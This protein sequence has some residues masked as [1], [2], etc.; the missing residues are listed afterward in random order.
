MIKDS[1]HQDAT[2]LKM[3]ARVRE[4]FKNITV[5]LRGQKNRHSHTGIHILTLMSY[6]K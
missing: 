4:R 1:I 5:K 3:Q 2:I 6:S